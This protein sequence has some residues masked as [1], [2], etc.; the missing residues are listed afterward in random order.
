MRLCCQD[1]PR[2]SSCLRG[3]PRWWWGEG[4]GG[5]RRQQALRV[6]ACMHFASPRGRCRAFDGC[7]AAVGYGMHR[8]CRTRMLC[9]AEAAASR[10][11]QHVGVG[12][13]PGGGRCYNQGSLCRTP[14]RGCAAAAGQAA[15]APL[16]ADG[17]MQEGRVTWS[18]CV[19][20][21]SSALSCSRRRRQLPG[22]HATAPSSGKNIMVS[23]LA[24]SHA[25]VVA[26][27]CGL[28]APG[29]KG[30]VRYLAARA[31]CPIMLASAC[32]C[33]SKCLIRSHCGFGGKLTCTSTAATHR[34]APAAVPQRCKHCCTR[35]EHE[36]AA[37]L[38]VSL[39]FCHAAAHPAA[40]GV[41]MAQAVCLHTRRCR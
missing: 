10:C 26:H 15:V 20:I 8:C 5:V 21:V 17:L 3:R 35:G 36:H 11:R 25:L 28:A 4:G 1:G 27:L 41:G 38:P 31:C 33:S 30:L 18:G 40:G 29:H 7:T 13:G 16:A 6:C 32:M 22:R 2:A 12:P 23:H 14:L 39:A 19:G 9:R 34:A 24:K 37:Q